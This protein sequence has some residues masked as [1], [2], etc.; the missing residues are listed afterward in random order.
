MGVTR[1][2]AILNLAFALILFAGA[3]VI[4]PASDL[5]KQA[6]PQV[7]VTFAFFGCNRIDPA[8]WEETRSENPSSANLPQLKQTVVDVSKLAP[9]LLFFGGD[10]VLGYADDKGQVLGS[11]MSAWMAYVNTLPRARKTEYIAISGNHEMNRKAH[12]AK[13]P[14]LAADAVW[15][16]LIT[17]SGFVP[18]DSKG[19]TPESAKH[20]N[21]VDDQRAL[22]FSFDRGVAHFVVLNT[23]TRVSTVDHETGETKIGMIPATWLDADLDAAE[24]NPKIKVV[25]VM[26]HRNVI[27][28]ASVKGDAPIDPECAAPMIKSLESHRKVLAYVCAHVHAFD[29]SPIGSTGLRQTCFG[30]GGSSLEKS[31]EP[32]R[33]RTFG[34]GYFKVYKDGSLG[35]VPYLRPEPKNYMDSRPDKVPPARPERELILPARRGP[36]LSR[37]QNER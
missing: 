15:S 7:D 37:A 31:W 33:G 20:D 10:L 26:D 30:N 14:S 32:V 13:L 29:I 34:F 12:G 36:I 24:R 5:R 21:L 6:A 28:P 35:V 17:K 18:H 9:D 2:R 4:V 8:D 3:T 23:D 19:P 25:I 27:D 1:K 16:K 22:S 11:Q